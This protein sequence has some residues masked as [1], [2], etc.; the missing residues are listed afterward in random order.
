MMN[1]EQKQ[2]VFWSDRSGVRR[3]ASVPNV[4]NI[5]IG[6][7]VTAIDYKGGTYNGNRPLPPR[8]MQTRDTEILVFEGGKIVERIAGTVATAP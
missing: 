2:T 6:R 3:T 1:T 7:D 5:Q 8:F 4:P